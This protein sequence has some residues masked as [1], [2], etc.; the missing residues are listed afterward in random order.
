MRRDCGFRLER[1]AVFALALSMY[2]HGGYSW[3]GVGVLFLVP[4][5]NLAAYLAGPRIAT[6]RL[7]VLHCSI[8]R[9]EQ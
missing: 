1:L 5:I 3:F 8:E 9:C 2:A 7:A 4:D 6:L